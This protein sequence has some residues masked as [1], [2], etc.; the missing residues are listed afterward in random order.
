MKKF[1]AILIQVYKHVLE[2]QAPQF[3]G[4][5]IR[6]STGDVAAALSRPVEGIFSADVDE[7][8]AVR[9]GLLLA[10]QL[11]LEVKWGGV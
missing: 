10:K 4:A 3:S 9:E 7:F 5:V 6:N 2:S 1:Q 11:H 8:L